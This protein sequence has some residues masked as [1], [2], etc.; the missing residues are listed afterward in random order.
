MNHDA[1]IREYRAADARAIEA[2]IVELQDYER[3]IDPR[4]RPGSS[5]AAEYL[6]QTLARCNDYTG[7]VFVAECANVVAGFTTV[8][9][10]MP[11]LELDDPPG[12]FALITDLVVL[13]RFRRQGYGRALLDAA[14]RFARNSGA[15]ELR[16]GVLS[17]NRTAK[18][19]YAR[20]GFGSHA[21]VLTKRFDR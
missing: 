6:A 8:L 16:I 15:T 10:R 9:A 7:R 5:M 17:A 3:Q 19:L 1:V 2:C 14:E 13:E 4:L 12:E 21:E 20:A 11:F 18:D